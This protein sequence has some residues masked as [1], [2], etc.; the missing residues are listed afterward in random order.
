MSPRRPTLIV[1]TGPTASGKTSLAIDLAERLECEIISAD[2]RQIFKDIPIG[3]AAP[4]PAELSRVHHHLVSIL[5]LTDYYSAARFETDALGL[6]PGIFGRS[7][8]YALVCGGSMMYVDALVKGIDAMPTV[9]DE[10]RQKVLSLLEQHGPEGVTAL[11]EILDPPYYAE[12]D[13][14]N[15]RR[16]VHAVEIS[17]QAGV[18]YSYL[19]T[20]RKALRDFDVVKFAIDRPREDLFARINSRVD[21]MIANGMIDEARRVYPMRH[22]NSLNTV[23]YKELFAFFDGTMDFDT[24]VARIK[25]N[26]RVYAKKQITWLRRDPSVTW[27]APT[28]SADEIIQNLIR[29]NSNK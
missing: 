9:S 13:R 2:S 10:I 7:G 29:R 15:I 5:E 21:S 26:T 12:V 16:V 22:L 17:M 4:T 24:A 28:V 6:L 1:V 27:L 14:S 23:G 25:K 18:P 20:G 19:R 3:T 8:G 11:L